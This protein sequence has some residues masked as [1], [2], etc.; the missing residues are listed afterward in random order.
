MRILVI[1]EIRNKR[2]FDWIKTYLQNISYNPNSP[3]INGRLIFFTSQNFRCCKIIYATSAGRK[4]EKCQWNDRILEELY[5]FANSWFKLVIIL[6]YVN[7]L[8]LNKIIVLSY[9]ISKKLVNMLL[10]L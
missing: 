7:R 8:T 9:I 1:L 10:Q 4:C 5:F 2:K 6:L 3:H